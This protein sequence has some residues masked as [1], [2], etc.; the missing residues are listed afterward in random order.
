MK[1]VKAEFASTNYAQDSVHLSL[2]RELAAYHCLCPKSFQLA[3]NVYTGRLDETNKN[4][5]LHWSRVFEWPWAILNAEL[6]GKKE[7][8]GLDIGGGHS[9]FQ[10]VA[11]KRLQHLT[12]LDLPNTM[13]IP[14]QIAECFNMAITQVEGDARK[15][16]FDD[17]SFDRFFCI[18]VLEHISEWRTVLD[19]A[20]RV[21]I[22]GGI[23]IVTL[24]VCYG[25][26]AKDHSVISTKD[27][28]DLMEKYGATV[29][30]GARLS[31]TMPNGDDLFCLCLK[32]VKENEVEP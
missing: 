22:S 4:S 10:Y 21:L 15:L 32:F 17:C 16:P 8:T 29:M 13:G 3:M 14:R 27:V 28:A 18:S 19:E 25:N 23:A 5:A 20:F 31:N 6:N 24:D 11:S 7:C 30:P 12:N 26:P 2:I 1:L 9:V